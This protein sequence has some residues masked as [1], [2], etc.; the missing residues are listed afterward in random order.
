MMNQSSLDNAVL[1]K[2]D[3][4][5]I[6]NVI[7][8]A[9]LTQILCEA[10]SETDWVPVE[11][12][13]TK[14]RSALAWKTDGLMD[15]IWEMIN[16]LDFSKFELEFKT[17]SLWRDYPTYYI[18]EHVDNECVQAAMQ[19]Y[20]SPGPAEIGTRFE[21]VEI[22]YVPNTGYIMRNQNKLKHSMK[23]PVPWGVTRY[24]LYALF[25]VKK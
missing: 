16:E 8:P 17:V 11:L 5:S 7:D 23:R 13:E 19:I 22:P 24:S 6:S 3:L 25:A 21:T 1:L 9:T 20:L 15:R 10:E 2:P 4:W 12:Q 18:T 14:P